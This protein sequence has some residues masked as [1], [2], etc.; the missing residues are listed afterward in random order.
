[1]TNFETFR[2]SHQDAIESALSRAIATINSDNRYILSGAISHSL[3]NGGKRIRPLLTIASHSLFSSNPNTIFP[4]AISLEIIHTYSLIHD[5]LPSMDNDD[6]RRGKPTCHIQFG[7]DIAILAGDT[8]NTLAFEILATQLS[9]FP[10]KEVLNLIAIVSK[11]LGI[12]GL[13]G[14]QVLDLRPPKTAATL[15]QLKHLHALKTGALI[16]LCIMGPAHLHQAKSPILDLL[17]RLSQHIGLLFQIIDDIL[18]VTGDKQTLGKSPGKDEK[19]DKLTY[20]SLMSLEKAT[21][22]AQDEKNAALSI[23]NELN[24]SYKLNT[25]GLSYCINYIATRAY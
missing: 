1:M 12:H 17:T 18:D 7:E 14:G 13:V 25:Q 6:L 9:D 16:E 11:N 5:D 23:L 19:L 15:E 22:M 4:L 20:P 2:T 8:L 21:A 10:A 24:N 3:L